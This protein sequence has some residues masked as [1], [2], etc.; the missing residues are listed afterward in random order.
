MLHDLRLTTRVIFV[1]V[2]AF[3]VNKFLLRPYVLAHE[4]PLAARIFVLSVPNFLEAIAGSML[5]CNLALA[6][7]HRNYVGIRAFS[8][9]QIYCAAVVVTAIYVVSQEFKLHNLGGANVYDP[10]D[11]VFSVVGLFLAYWLL[12]ILKPQIG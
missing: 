7:R 10:F 11:V 9:Q 4:F 8:N 12:Q 3:V 1:V 6:G 5:L 2:V